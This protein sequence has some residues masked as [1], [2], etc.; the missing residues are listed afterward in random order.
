M[1]REYCYTCSSASLLPVK[2]LGRVASALL[3]TLSTTD[4]TAAIPLEAGEARPAAWPPVS[5]GV[6]SA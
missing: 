3:T 2:V 1:R 6:N 5:R 4:L